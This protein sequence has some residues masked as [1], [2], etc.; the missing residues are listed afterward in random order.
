[1]TKIGFLAI[2]VMMMAAC[3]GDD[4]GGDVTTNPASASTAN[5]NVTAFT[6][7]ID[8]DDGATAAGGVFTL[9]G[10]AQSVLTPTTEGARQL[11]VGPAAVGD[12]TC[13]GGSCTFDGCGDGST[14]TIDG[15]ITT[16]GDTY[17]VD[18]TMAWSFGGNEW[19]WTYDGA[20]TVTDT[21]IDGSFD[22]EGSASFTNPNDNSEFEYEYVWG[23]D[24]NEVELDGTG[25]AIGGTLDASVDYSV[26]GAQGGGNYSGS[27]TVTFG[28]TCGE[29]S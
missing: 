21:S 20:L 3:G 12:C 7:A 2:G 29:A 14:Y 10:T 13:E 8:G 1:M 4:D 11:P 26:S 15:T 5:S 23:L 18:L 6:A 22:G 24:W 28:P 9:N 17:T 16:E 19:T 25:C 27:G